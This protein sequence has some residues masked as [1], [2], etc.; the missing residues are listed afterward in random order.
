MSFP[1]FFD[2]VPSLRMCDPLSQLLGA[3]PDGVIEYHYADAV[4]LAGHSCPTVAGAWLS[5]RAGLKALYPDELPQRGG[6]SVYL[7]EREDQGV[8]GVIAQ[9]LTL[10]TGAA[11]DNG[12]KGIGGHHVRNHLLHYGE[13]GMGGMR[14]RRNDSG[15]TLEVQY[16][17]STVVG[18]PR[19]R[20]LL[21]ALLH[22]QADAAQEQLFAELWQDRVRRILLEHAD[23]P[24]V[25]RVREL[26]PA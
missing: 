11:A 2:Q 22:G 24:A 13:P 17:P 8:T 25:V 12:F 16:N 9:V 26:Q 14:M 21:Q 19:Q 10:V 20:E 4:R 3:T 5:A 23:D 15:R 7:S 1:A 18:D 6:I